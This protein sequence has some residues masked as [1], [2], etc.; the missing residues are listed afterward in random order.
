MLQYCDFNR[1]RKWV[2]LVGVQ[3]RRINS[4][5]KLGVVSPYIPEKPFVS[6]E[7]CLPTHEMFGKAATY[8]LLKQQSGNR[9]KSSRRLCRR[10]SQIQ[11]A[12]TAS[13]KKNQWLDAMIKMPR[14]LPEKGIHDELALENKLYSNTGDV[15][16]SRG[17]T[18]P[19]R[20][21]LERHRE[22]RK[23]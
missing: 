17:N 7:P 16:A 15:F 13:E 4:I 5:A 21:L 11:L 22:S 1:E 14:V 9:R 3:Y 8:V 20:R 10:D 23:L 2:N 12:D 6:K 18:S 19:L